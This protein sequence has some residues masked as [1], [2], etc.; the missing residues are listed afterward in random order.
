MALKLMGQGEDSNFKKS[1]MFFLFSQATMALLSKP[2]WSEVRAWMLWEGQGSNGTSEEKTEEEKGHQM[3]L[4][5]CS[6][7]GLFDPRTTGSPH[8]C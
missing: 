8:L 4:K 6:G 2:T 7:A 3:G 1:I 5:G